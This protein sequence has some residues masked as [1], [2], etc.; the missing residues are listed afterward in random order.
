MNE[1]DNRE[2]RASSVADRGP[3]T[4]RVPTDDPAG[5]AQAAHSVRARDKLYAARWHLEDVF[6]AGCVEHVLPV[7]EARER[8]AVPAAADEAEA[9]VRR[10]L[11]RDAAHAAAPATKGEVFGGQS[12]RT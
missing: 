8:L 4:I 9:G 7:E 5:E 10:N 6:S 12:H 11:A 2:T 1:A 3:A